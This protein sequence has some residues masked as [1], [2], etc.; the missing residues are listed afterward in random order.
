MYRESFLL[1][2]GLTNFYMLLIR[3]KEEEE[4]SRPEMAAFCF[5][6]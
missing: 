3:K 4:L 5:K 6:N 1:P 2:E